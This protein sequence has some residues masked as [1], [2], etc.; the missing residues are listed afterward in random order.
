MNPGIRRRIF[1]I[2][3]NHHFPPEPLPL[4]EGPGGDFEG[5]IMDGKRRRGPAVTAAGIL[6]ALCISGAAFGLSAAPADVYAGEG[7]PEGDGTNM[8]ATGDFETTLDGWGLYLEGGS[9]EIAINDLGEMELRIAGVGKVDYGVQDYYDGFSLDEGC[10]YQ[11]DFDV[12]CTIEREI[13]WRAQLNGGDYHAYAENRIEVGPERRHIHEE[14]TMEEPSD[15]APRFCFNC[16]VSEGYTDGDPEHVITF[17][18]ITLVMTGGSASAE[19]D[20]EAGT[21]PAIVCS[22]TG[23]LPASV[24]T[25]TLRGEAAHGAGVFEVADAGTGEV[26]LEGQGSGLIDNALSGE[27]LR[28]LDFS[29]LTD[30]GTYELT[31][32]GAEPVLIEIGDG[33]YDGLAGSVLRFF[34]LARCGAEVDDGS[35]GHPACHTS[36]AVLY[37]NEDETRDVQGG[38]HDAGDY[39]RY[40]VSGAKAAADLLLAFEDFC[41]E[42]PGAFSGIPDIVRPELEWLLRMQE[43]D[44]GVHHKVTCASFPGSVMPEEETDRLVLMPVSTAATGDFAAVMAIAA[45]VYRD[46]RCPDKAF[47]ERC[48]EAAVLAW[49]YLGSHPSDPVGFKNPEGITTGEYPDSSDAD[50]RLWAAAE[51]LRTTGEEAYAEAL[52]L[53]GD[54]ISG[55]EFGWADVSGYAVY[56]ALRGADS[57]SPVHEAAR[58]ALEE[59]AEEA[60]KKSLG[61]GYGAALA[62][63]DYVWGSNMGAANKGMLLIMA[64]RACENE[65][66][67]AAAEKQ[68][69]YLLGNNTNGVCYV[70]GFGSS[71]PEH[72]HHRPSQA[73]GAAE[74]GMLVGGPDA[75]LE[76]PFAKN[77]LAGRAP[78]ACWADSDQSYSTNEVAIYW[79]SPLVFL[80]AGVILETSFG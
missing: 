12:E 3:M 62:A 67:E 66:Y 65:E 53:P 80:L 40:A 29:E 57:G 69:S 16:G 22:Q 46:D 24:K 25:A 17:D 64:A 60:L 26:V 70:T 35:Y 38:W 30:P 36:P 77:V 27:E 59:A 79:N 76:D 6:A 74:P 11:L 5:I 49:S 55:A 7:N 21:A 18:N 9:A 37:E 13:T 47:A 20:P 1:E 68:L 32:D 28:V 10:T 58:R 54:G 31:V 51:L 23:F 50:E 63:E 71:S 19:A 56:A 73:K 44:G 8:I 4:E 72:P 78:A 61:D 45:R 34:D 52:S 2:R 14:F 33:V 43:P 15:P 41:P 48:R 39:G 42:E 75:S